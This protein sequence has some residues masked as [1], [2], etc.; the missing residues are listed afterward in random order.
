MA[1]ACAPAQA[2]QNAKAPC[3][4]ETP[5]RPPVAP[6]TILLML[7]AL[8][9]RPRAEACG[10][11]LVA[12]LAEGAADIF[13]LRKATTDAWTVQRSHIDPR[14]TAGRH[15]LVATLHHPGTC[16]WPH[17]PPQS[18]KSYV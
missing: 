8:P 9:A 2:R 14:G 16:L 15:I 10:P 4:R 18:A 3:R 6:V 12:T 5:M 1:A 11:R 7:L 13:A 17:L